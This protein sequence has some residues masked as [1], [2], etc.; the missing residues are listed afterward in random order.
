[1]RV[2]VLLVVMLTMM[3]L[4]Q[5][6][7]VPARRQPIA[8]T[9]PDGTTV[10]VY[11]CGD[12]Y[13]HFYTTT[14]GVPVTRSEDGY[15]YYTQL[16]AENNPVASSYKVI[17]AEP[18]HIDNGAVLQR[19][20]ELNAEKRQLKNSSVAVRRA[21]MSK[22]QSS[23]A[24]EGGAVRGLIILVNFHDKTFI[25]PQTKIDDMMNKEGYP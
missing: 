23:V 12:E 11:L 24:S 4:G 8:F 20:S 2:K 13:Q 5:L 21:P 14:D 19:Y 17:E 6:M 15:F 10:T 1:M 3:T 16:D 7:A 9:Q 22:R 18:L 25:T